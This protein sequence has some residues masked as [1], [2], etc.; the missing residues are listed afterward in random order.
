MRDKKAKSKYEFFETVNNISAKREEKKIVDAI[1]I[2]RW[3]HESERLLL[4]YIYLSLMY[5]QM[6]TLH[7]KALKEQSSFK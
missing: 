7:A 1:E 3:L 5:I 6:I 2:E 4:I